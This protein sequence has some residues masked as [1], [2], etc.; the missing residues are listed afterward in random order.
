MAVEKNAELCNSVRI[1]QRVEGGGAIKGMEDRGGRREWESI[2]GEAVD[3]RRRDKRKLHGNKEMDG[4][5]RSGCRVPKKKKKMLQ[6]CWGVTAGQ[7]TW[8]GE[9]SLRSL[10]RGEVALLQCGV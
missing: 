5:G 3:G 4:G 9:S 10:Q 1:E 8:G 7:M 2:G 6:P